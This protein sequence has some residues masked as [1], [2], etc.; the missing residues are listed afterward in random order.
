MEGK[1]FLFKHQ[2]DDFEIATSS[3]RIA[4]IFFDKIVDLLTFPLKYMGLVTMSNGIDVLQTRD[5][6]NILV[7]TYIERIP[8]KHSNS[9]M[10]ISQN[11]E[12]PTPLAHCPKMMQNILNAGGSTDEKFQEDLAER[13]GFGYHNGIG[14]LVYAMITCCPDLSYLVVCCARNTA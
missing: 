2:V 5:Y 12:Y 10:K 1:H 9:W 3:G 13:M 14:E 6:F 8:E 7:Q 11:L 4:N